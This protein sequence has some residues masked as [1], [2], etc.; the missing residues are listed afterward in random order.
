MINLIKSNFTH[1]KYLISNTFDVFEIKD[2][3]LYHYKKHLTLLLFYKK[4]EINDK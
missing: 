3:L 2:F 1:R 4:I